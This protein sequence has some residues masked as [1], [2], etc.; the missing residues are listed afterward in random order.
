MSVLKR[1]TPD[2]IGAVLQQ[3]TAISILTADTLK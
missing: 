1:E 2:P 3:S